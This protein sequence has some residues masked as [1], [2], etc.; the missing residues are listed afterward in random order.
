MYCR[1]CGN[2]I[3]DNAFVCPKCGVKVKDDPVFVTAPNSN[4]AGSGASASSSSSSVSVSIDGSGSGSAS[5]SKLVFPIATLLCYIFL[6]PIGFILNIVGL[7][8]GEKK[9]CFWSMLITFFVIPIFC[10]ICFLFLC[11]VAVAVEDEGNNTKNT[12][13]SV[14]VAN[15]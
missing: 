7:F 5:D 11:C 13:S 4:G 14:Q 9:G 10:I 8:S 12:P 2:E 3:S 15:P 6:Y 1:N